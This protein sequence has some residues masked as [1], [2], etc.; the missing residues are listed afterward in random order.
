MTIT[1]HA[2]AVKTS[3][4]GADFTMAFTAVRVAVPE[5]KLKDMETLHVTVAPAELDISM[6]SRGSDVHRMGVDIGVQIRPDDKSN[7]SI[8]PLVSFVTELANHFSRLKLTANSETA[9]WKSVGVEP[10]YDPATLR[11][12]NQFLSV[13]HLEYEVDRQC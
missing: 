11:E 10:V 5:F 8:D 1:Q 4:N 3:I 6:R 12:K 2:E 13:I 9:T 7:A